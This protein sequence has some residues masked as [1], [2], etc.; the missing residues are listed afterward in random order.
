MDN[1]QSVL[2]FLGQISDVLAIRRRQQNSLHARPQCANQ[3]LLD[4]A[5]GQD[6]AAEGNFA[7]ASRHTRTHTS[8][9]SLRVSVTDV[10]TAGEREK[11][12][13]SPSWRWWGAQLGPKTTRSAQWFVRCRNWGHLWVWH[14]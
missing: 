9:V 13:N 1:S 3:L 8:R 4:S 6:L 14:R 2:D 7:L 12:K 5:D 10:S 11:K